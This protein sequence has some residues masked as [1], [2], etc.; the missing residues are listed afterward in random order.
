MATGLVVAAA[1]GCVGEE[2]PQAHRALLLLDQEAR[3]AGFVV[4]GESMESRALPIAVSIDEPVTL[5]GPQ[6]SQ[7]IEVGP[8]EIILV[9]GAT[10]EVEHH[11]LGEDVDPD[12][13]VL[14]APAEIVAEVADGLG[15]EVQERA[16]G[17]VE[18]VAPGVLAASA[19]APALTEILEASVV[20]LAARTGPIARPS[21]RRPVA[22]IA[23]VSEPALAEPPVITLYEEPLVLSAH[24][25]DFMD[26]PPVASCEDSVE[27]TWIARRYFP[28][29]NDWYFFTMKID[30]KGRALKGQ[31]LAH[32]WTGGPSDTNTAQACEIGGEQ[33]VVQ[34]PATGRVRDGRIEFGGTEWSVAEHTC[35]WA[36]GPGQYNL[37]RFSGSVAAD[38]EAT[39]Q[40]DDGGRMT[41]EP[42]EFRRISCDAR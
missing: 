8:D 6:G 13:L 29:E 24:D 36:P 15:A 18:I 19:G 27:G 20:E 9:R 16:D 2:E 5:A 35:G 42:F 3:E 28:G 26:L 4:V 12:R 31:I 30:R 33:W 23:P 11:V 34:M 41:A 38:G 39:W 7:Q 10:G 14:A 37:D 21:V 17:R 22:R 32:S 1:A 25:A 40:N